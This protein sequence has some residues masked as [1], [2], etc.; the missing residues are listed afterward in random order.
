MG[1]IRVGGLD[2]TL[3]R[4]CATVLEADAISIPEQWR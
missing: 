2:L 4:V 1:T 3:T